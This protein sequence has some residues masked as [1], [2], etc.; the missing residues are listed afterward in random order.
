MKKLL[1]CCCCLM[2]AA[3]LSGC[4]SIQE[5]PAVS[6][7]TFPPV[8]ALTDAPK[9]DGALRSETSFPL[10]L[11]AA[12]GE[13]LVAQI[14]PV[15]LTLGSTNAE[16]VLRALFGFEANPSVQLITQGGMLSLAEEQPVQV[17]NGIAFVSLTAESTNIQAQDMYNTCMAITATLCQME[18][19]THVNFF[20]NGKAMGMDNR[21]ILP[22]GT[23]TVQQ[24]NSLTK[25]WETV[26]SQQVPLGYQLSSV[27]LYSAATLFYPLCS[28][29]GFMPELRTLAFPGQELAQ[30]ATVLMDAL[31]TGADNVDQMAPSLDSRSLLDSAPI[32]TADPSSFANR[33]VILRF[34]PDLVQR[35]EAGQVD[36]ACYL[37]A[38]V[39]TLTTFIPSVSTVEVLLGDDPLT[40]VTHPL[41]GTLSV[42]RG[43]LNRSMFLPLLA[44]PVTL[45]VPQGDTLQMKRGI[46]AGSE[47]SSSRKIL[48]TLFHTLSNP[49]EQG[50]IFM[51]EALDNADIIGVSITEGLLKVNLSG[52]AAA[53]ISALPPESEQLFLYAMVN[54]LSYSKSVKRVAFFFEGDQ[55]ESLAGR[56]FWTGSFLFAPWQGSVE[57][58]VSYGSWNTTSFISETSKG[59]D[60]SIP[61]LVVCILH[62]WVINQA[63]GCHDPLPRAG[64]AW[65]HQRKRTDSAFPPP[66]DTVPGHAL[67]SGRKR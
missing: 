47:S 16:A 7:V 14:S 6:S 49:D 23:L 53:V 48:E 18:E 1:T 58:G 44:Q 12:N 41:L 37:G 57:P 59:M 34:K 10:Y 22:L 38:V 63:A 33:R 50:R 35:L 4:W 65:H 32:V 13:Q 11:P 8:A 30:Q 27:P 55:R 20:L 19:I 39:N 26:K 42:E 40:E 66:D 62:G 15:T 24:G 31:S 29:E 43:E 28:G 64:S 51:P 36:L 56:V 54:T 21:N 9:D 2:M 46:L 45:F 52:R 5:T 61:L 17:S 67:S 60:D 25:Q 3:A